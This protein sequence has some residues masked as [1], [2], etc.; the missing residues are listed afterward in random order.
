MTSIAK[1]IAKE[2]EE[3]VIVRRAMEKGIVSMKSLAVYLIKQKK[4]DASMDAVVSAIRRFKEE[5]PLEMKY[6]KA[7]NVIAK[8]S[9]IRITTN[10]VEIAVE[11]NEENQRTL[12]KAFSLVRYEKGEILLVIQGE[13]STKLIIN[14]KNREKILSLFSRKS[15]IDIED[16]LAEINVRLSQDAVKTPGII[17]TLSTEFMLH[18]INLY[19]SMSCV[20]E[21]MFFV[22]Q[23][24]IAKSYEI[25]SNLVKM[26]E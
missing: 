23:K 20:P 3:D 16:N 12:Q 25:L 2:I 21:M 13:E 7:K 22:K 19:E 6:E 17:S 10:I 14:A 9:E 24:D 15:I 26:E 18:D 4:I 5:S 8:S 11:K 1:Q